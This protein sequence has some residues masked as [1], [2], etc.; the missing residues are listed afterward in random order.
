MITYFD[1]HA[2]PARPFRRAVVT[3]HPVEDPDNGESWV[4]AARDGRDHTLVDAALIID[5]VP[6]TPVEREPTPRA[7]EADGLLGLVGAEIETVVGEL[8]ELDCEDPA[9]QHVGRQLLASLLTAIGPVHRALLDQ[10]DGADGPLAIALCHLDSAIE[11]LRDGD[12]ANG[13]V[14]LA[15]AHS[16]IDALLPTPTDEAAG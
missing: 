5:V 2:G 12:V 14:A 8:V 6:R 11:H 9:T 16:A 1:I 4:P 10:V 15:I 7:S 3:G 13:R